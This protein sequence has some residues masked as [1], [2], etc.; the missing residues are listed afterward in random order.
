MKKLYTLGLLIMLSAGLFAQSARV[1]S[2]LYLNNNVAKMG[3]MH[4]LAASDTIFF[5]PFDGISVS[6]VDTANFAIKAEDLDMH[7]SDPG[8]GLTGK[9]FA[10]YKDGR[11]WILRPGDVDTAQYVAATSWFAPPGQADNWLEFGPITISGNDAMLS[12]YFRTTSPRYRDGYEVLI[13]T[14]GIN[15]ADF[16]D[17]AI[18]SRADCM[19]TCSVTASTDTMWQKQSA[20]VGQLGPVWIAFHHNANDMDKIMFD[21]IVITETKT[22]NVNERNTNVLSLS[23]MPNPAVN[24]TVI[25]YELKDAAPVELSLVDITGKKVLSRSEGMREQGNHQLTV[26]ISRLAPGMYFYTLTAGNNTMTRKMSV[27]K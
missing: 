20:P 25:R 18:Y 5:W 10:I 21:D 2:G 8:N 7:S 14:T 13:S 1:S 11:P 24:S 16:T 27:V 17:A 4:V 15:N 3:D 9:T 23:N 22:S 6:G 19:N 12:W 26:D